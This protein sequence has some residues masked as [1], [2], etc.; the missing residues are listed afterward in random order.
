MNDFIIQGIVNLIISGIGRVTIIELLKEQYPER[1]FSTAECDRLIQ[2]SKQAIQQRVS[3]DQKQIAVINISRYEKIF[4]YFDSIGNVKGALKA[5]K[6]KDRL[7]GLGYENKITLNQN[8][9]P[10]RNPVEYNE[11]LLTEAERVELKNLLQLT[12]PNNAPQIAVKAQI[13][14][15]VPETTQ[16]AVII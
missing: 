5:L 16:V 9:I 7:A 10:V 2:T 8:S 15:I 6:S 14:E 3:V 11:F 4:N 12:T 13:G 1:N